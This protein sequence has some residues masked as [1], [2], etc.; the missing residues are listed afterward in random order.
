MLKPLLFPALRPT[1]S[2]TLFSP[3]LLSPPRLPLLLSLVSSVCLNF[4]LRNVGREVDTAVVFPC[5]AL[6]RVSLLLL[7]V[8]DCFRYSGHLCCGQGKFSRKNGKLSPNLSGL[9]YKTTKEHRLRAT[10]H[11]AITAASLGGGGVV[12]C[13]NRT[14]DMP[15]HCPEGSSAFR[16]GSK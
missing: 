6:F 3:S 2:I 1:L 10:G 13:S 4:L 15:E 5:P 11:E 14:Q 7:P 12:I 9:G 16:P 8:F